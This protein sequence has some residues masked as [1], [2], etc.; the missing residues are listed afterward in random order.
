MTPYEF[1]INNT[2]DYIRSRGNQLDAANNT[3]LTVFDAARVLAIAFI[4]N[5]GEVIADLLGELK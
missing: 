4:K 5:Q 2:K 3:Q 1:A